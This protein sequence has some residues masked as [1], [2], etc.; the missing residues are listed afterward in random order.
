MKK[1]FTAVLLSVILVFAMTGCNV[2]RSEFPDYDV[3]GYVNAL[4][5]S[6][7]HNNS[8]DLIEIT[9]QSQE[10]ADKNM[11]ITIDNG[12]VYFCNAFAINPS[13][14]QMQQIRQLVEKAYNLSKYTVK[15]KTEATNGYD[16]IVEIEPITV[17]ADTITEANALRSNTKLL[18]EKALDKY[19]T[20]TNDVYDEDEETSDIIINSEALTEVFID[21]VIIMCET[22]LSSNFI[23]GNPQTVTLKILRTDDGQLQIDTTQLEEIDICVVVFQNKQ[24]SAESGN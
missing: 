15:P 3:T 4:L 18:R 7:Y 5:G 13:D 23:Y 24:T 14:E 6:S 20:P 10:D 17:F 8:E 22:K 12:S 16:V 2:F 1:R 11:Q 19:S 21:E 9:M